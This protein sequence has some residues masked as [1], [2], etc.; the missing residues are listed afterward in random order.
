MMGDSQDIQSPT[1]VDLWA[2]S[3]WTKGA[4]QDDHVTPGCGLWK[5]TSSRS[6]TD[7][8]W[9]GDEDG[10]GSLWTELCSTL[11]HAHDDDVDV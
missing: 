9:P 2:S 10:R 3:S 8:T 4:T 6:T 11:G 1:Y 5:L 7:S